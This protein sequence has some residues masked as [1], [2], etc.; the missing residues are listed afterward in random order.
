MSM[1]KEIASHYHMT[2]QAFRAVE[3]YPTLWG[4][5]T[6]ANIPVA[7][8][9]NGYLHDFAVIIEI[10]PSSTRDAILYIIIE[11]DL[12]RPAHNRNRNNL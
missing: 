2:L 12:S 8:N 9:N 4:L 11:Q 3:T 7:L 1:L 10:S 6:I 5:E